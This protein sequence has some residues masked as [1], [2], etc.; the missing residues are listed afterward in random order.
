MNLQKKLYIV[1]RYVKYFHLFLK[2]RIF[3]TKLFSLTGDYSYRFEHYGSEFFQLF[4]DGLK[5]LSNNN[6]MS[7]IVNQ[8]L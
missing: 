6:S 7:D 5:T 3:S 1:L 2:C 4:V 8:V